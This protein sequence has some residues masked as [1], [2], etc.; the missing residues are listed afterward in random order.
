MRKIFLVIILL[1]GLTAL[2]SYADMEEHM[3]GSGKMSSADYGEAEYGHM[4]YY[5][6]MMGYGMMGPG[7]MMG[8]CMMGGGM[9]GL[10]MMGYGGYGMMGSG[11]MGYG[12]GAGMMWKYDN[13]EAYQKFLDDTADLRRQLY[14]KR[15]EY[16][17]ALR[18]LRTKSE[19]LK[20]LEKEI[21]ELRRKI[22]E[23]VPK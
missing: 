17:E 3:R 18:N 2:Y 16:F 9:M 8:P 20:K 6:Q 5:P 11:M 15:F 14:T 19:T 21:Q 12:M 13:V 10:G 1:I 22:S 23:K 4:S 7:M